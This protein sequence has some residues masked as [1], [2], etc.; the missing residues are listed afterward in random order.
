MDV[1]IIIINYNTVLLL[2]NAIDSVL[3]KTKEISYEIIVL[4]NHSSDNSAEII[5]Q[6]YGDR[7][8]YIRLPENIG[9]G[10]ANN[11]A[12][13]IA[14]GRNILLL[15][16]DTILLNNA[17]KI[18]S[19]YLDANSSCGC[20]GG[21]L[22]DESGKPVISFSRTFPSV[23]DEINQLLLGIPY[24]FFFGRNTK[25]NNSGR[26]LQVA[27]VIGADMMIKQQ[28]LLKVGMFDPDFFM[29]HEELELGYRI[30]KAHYQ[31]VSVPS[32]K[33]VHLEGK[34]HTDNL[35]RLRKVLKARSLYLRKTH[36][37]KSIFIANCIFFVTSITRIIIF[38]LYGK[39]EKV[40][41]WQ[42]ILR[43]MNRL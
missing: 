39:K 31:I 11:E 37:V 14:N 36:G 13:K 15:N 7:V 38:S 17:V 6:K 18:L 12:M 40:H 10:R 22:Y 1:S 35:E 19:D 25:F 21:N 23:W 24:K 16:P 28:V 32:A 43:N 34:S 5:P 9:F 41:Y 20:C 30:K 8:V 26:N 33:I 2:C 3:D 4:D 29:Y 27:C 42:F